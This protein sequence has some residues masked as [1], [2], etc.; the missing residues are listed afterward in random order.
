VI[1]DRGIQV[2]AAEVGGKWI[3]VP[4]PDGAPDR[5]RCAMFPLGRSAQDDFHLCQ[6]NR[7]MLPSCEDGV[8]GGI[9]E[10]TWQ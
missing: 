6:D 1:Y 5:Y 7:R 2:G 8:A 10:V 3:C 4:Y 9:V